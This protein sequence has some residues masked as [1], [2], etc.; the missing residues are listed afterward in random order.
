MATS[1]TSKNIKYL[2]ATYTFSNDYDN[3]ESL[4]N[5]NKNVNLNELI[6]WNSEIENVVEE[7]EIKGK[8]DIDSPIYYTTLLNLASIKGNVEIVELLLK[9]GALPTIR[10]GRGRYNNNNSII[11]NIH[12]CY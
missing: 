3:V 8:Y 11:I 4:V 5:E 7:S 2:L 1:N 10:D 6:V 12:Y 9:H